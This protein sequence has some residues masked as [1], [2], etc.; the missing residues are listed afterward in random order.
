MQGLAERSGLKGEVL[1]RATPSSTSQVGGTFQTRMQ[2]QTSWHSL[3]KTSWHSVQKK[4]LD[5]VA[6][7]KK[8]LLDILGKVFSQMAALF[9]GRASSG[10]GL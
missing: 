8:K 4:L 7:S 1:N 9:T 3:K 5:F 10:L 2:Q 6:F